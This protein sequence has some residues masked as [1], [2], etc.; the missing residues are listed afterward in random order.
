MPRGASGDQFFGDGLGVV[1]RDREPDADVAGLLLLTAETAAARS[2]GGDRRVDA[3]QLAPAV[4]QRA[5]GVAR[6]DR[7]VGLDGV[8]NRVAVLDVGVAGPHR[9]VHGADDARGHGAVQAEGA[10]DRDH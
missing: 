4:D 9:P 6:V 5:A 7:G 8:E 1:G 10:A 3:D 2:H